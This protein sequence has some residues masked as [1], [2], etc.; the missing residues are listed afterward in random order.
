ML[1]TEFDSDDIQIAQVELNEIE[2]DRQDKIN[3][4]REMCLSSPEINRICYDRLDDQ[5]LVCYNSS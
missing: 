3:E 1:Y 5:F 4:L 2:H